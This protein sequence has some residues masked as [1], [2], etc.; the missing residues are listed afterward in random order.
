MTGADQTA[1]GGVA[2]RRIVEE[3]RHAVPHQVAEREMILERDRAFAQAV[4]GPDFEFFIPMTARH[5][6]T[7]LNPRGIRL[8]RLEKSSIV[9]HTDRDAHCTSPISKPRPIRIVHQARKDRR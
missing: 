4:N 5:N 6:P 1:I 9:D 3:E 7:F 2:P 8:T